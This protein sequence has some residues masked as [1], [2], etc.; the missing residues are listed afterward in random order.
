[1]IQNISNNVTMG[2]K[3]KAALAYVLGF[4]T[5]VPILFIAGNNSFVKFHAWQ[6]I[7]WSFVVAGV[8]TQILCIIAPDLRLLWLFIIIAYLLMAAIMVAIGRKFW[9]PVIGDIVD[10]WLVG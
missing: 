3:K 4:F 9:M 5:A 1:M 6:S 10:R 7:I 2:G 8:V